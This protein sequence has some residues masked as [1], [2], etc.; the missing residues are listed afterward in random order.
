MINAATSRYAILLSC[1]AFVSFF[2]LTL[3]GAPLVHFWRLQERAFDPFFYTAAAIPADAMPAWLA[4]IGD[5]TSLAR[6]NLPGTHDSAARYGGSSYECQSLTIRD[7][8]ELGIRWLDVRL[9]YDSRGVLQAQHGRVSQRATF[10]ELLADINAFLEA[11]PSEFVLLKVQ[12][13]KSTEQTKFGASVERD[14]ELSGANVFKR[15]VTSSA[16]LP[17]LGELRGKIMLMPRF[18]TVS[19]GT[20]QYEALVAQD[21]FQASIEQKR[22]AISTSFDSIAPVTALSAALGQK[23]AWIR[24]AQRS[25]L[26]KTGAAE[27][28]L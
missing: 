18:F 22:H 3:P 21:D 6:L 4:E 1:A 17:L 9:R 23:V 24:E 14:L 27:L 25:P 28:G 16:Q 26:A 20:I 7:Q 8:L 11:N 15:I 13:E 12:Q 10:P 5:E 2:L 19:F